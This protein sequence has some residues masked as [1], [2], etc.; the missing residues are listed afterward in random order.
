MLSVLVMN[1]SETIR[2]EL[3]Y[4]KEAKE[5]QIKVDG[6]DQIELVQIY[7]G[8][9]ML[10]EFGNQQIPPWDNIIRL[11]MDC[12]APCKFYYV[13]QTKNGSRHSVKSKKTDLNKNGT[14]YEIQ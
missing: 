7:A 5:L 2:L 14:F 4:D 9:K 10:V 13:I 1:D 8:E 3:N 12:P 11:K 6:K